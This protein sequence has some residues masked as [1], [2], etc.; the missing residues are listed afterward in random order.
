MDIT[1]SALYW[2][3]TGVM[4]LLL[5]MAVPGFILFFFGVGAWV[6]ALLSWLMPLGISS[7]ILIFTVSSVVSLLTLRRLVQRTFI[8]DSVSTD[9]PDELAEKGAHVE[10]VEEIIPP[11][12]GKVKYSGTTWRAVSDTSLRAGALAEIVAQDGLVMK[13]KGVAGEQE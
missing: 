13:V 1:T 8:G 3:I 7:Q 2:F 11:A 6:T 4:L 12:E 9:D 10:V 5:E